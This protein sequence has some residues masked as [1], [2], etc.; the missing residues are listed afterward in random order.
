MHAPAAS[1]DSYSTEPGTTLTV[2]A[3][4]VLSNDIDAQ[5]H[6]LTAAAKS[7]PAHGT[8]SFSADGSFEYVPAVGYSGVDSFTYQAFDG[9][10]FS[11]TVSV[12]LAVGAA[13]TPAPITHKPRP[14]HRFYNFKQG[15]HFYTASAAEKLN[16]QSRLF[17]TYAYEGVSYTLDTSTTANSAPLYRFYNAKKGAHFF[18]A[19]KAERDDIIARLGSMYHYE[20]V[21]YDV[22]LDPTGNLPVYRFYNVE[23]GVHFFTASEAERDDVTAR[24]GAT[25]QYEGIAYYYAPPR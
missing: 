6:E 8:L 22:S 13:V 5:G 19:S 18:T 12:S 2:P 25:Y 11:E 14:V 24:L 16:V 15:M 7:E 1:A 21:A 3:S 9:H 17:A 23:Q 20:G 10:A 4:G